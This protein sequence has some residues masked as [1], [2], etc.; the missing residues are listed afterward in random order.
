MSMKQNISKNHHYLPIFF[1]KGFVNKNG[2]IYVYDK[3]NDEFLPE[4]PPKRHFFTKHLNNYRLD[5]KIVSSSEKELYSPM[6]GKVASLFKK[7]IENDTLTDITTPKDKIDFLL[8][9]T[10]LFWRTPNSDALFKEIIEKEGVC[11]RY[12]GLYNE[13]TGKRL[14]DDDFPELKEKMLLD[15]EF[16][17]ISKILIPASDA[18]SEEVLGLVAK[19]KL[20]I[21]SSAS[22]M[23]FI[24]GD[25][26]IIYSNQNVK[27]G[28]IFDNLFF[29]IS[30][31]QV[32]IL[33]NNIPKF[34]DSFIMRGINLSII[35]SSKR[36]VASG[37]KDNLENLV[38]IYKGFQQL[39]IEKEIVENTF[40][41]IDYISKFND[42]D[43]YK[44]NMDFHTK[45][46]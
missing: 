4:S 5:G 9:L 8:F 16:L 1:Q 45:T 31:N 3:K 30:T 24:T 23:T 18:N 28:H 7:V 43:H 27:L 26:P 40:G 13:E 19:W 33:N 6:D 15:S 32:L 44:F 37:N 25:S 14:S 38:G 11:N 35:H 46:K 10:H 41:L 34:I 21:L 2:M 36:F 42:W 29:P 12:F 17:K 20:F 39:G 22:N